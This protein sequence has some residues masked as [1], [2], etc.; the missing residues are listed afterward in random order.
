MHIL[1]ITIAFV[2]TLAFFYGLF[3]GIFRRGQRG[4]GWLVV[5][6]SIFVMPI[7]AEWMSPLSEDGATNEGPEN[8]TA[9]EDAV[10][11]MRADELTDETSAPISTDASLVALER[12]SSLAAYCETL[13]RYDEIYQE[14]QQAFA[15][16]D[17]NEQIAWEREQEQLAAD[18]LSEELG[19]EANKWMAYAWDKGWDHRCDALSRNWLQIEP[20]D[21]RAATRDDRNRVSDAVELNY[22]QRL[23]R[24]EGDF[25]FDQENFSAVRCRTRGFGQWDIIG[26]N[27]VGG[28]GSSYSRS[29]AVYY[30]A[31]RADGE[32]V[33]VPID[34]QGE[35]HMVTSNLPDMNARQI[36]LGKYVGPYPALPGLDW[37]EVKSFFDD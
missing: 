18:S 26:C 1:G 33:I 36:S 16:G 9:V 29:G 35:D 13:V 21:I 23:D 12:P 7:A 34:N 8:A 32:P 14:A 30:V 19:V 37:A 28:W 4:K 31:A 5:L 6:A 27:M 22:I 10:L 3:L 24:D 20:D 15:G 2:S 17:I 25:F 11:A